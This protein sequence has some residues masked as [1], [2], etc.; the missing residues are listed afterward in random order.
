MKKV[1][2]IGGG[3]L[4]LSL[5]YELSQSGFAVTVLEK[6]KEWGGLASGLKIG[7]TYIEKYYHH[8]FRSDSAV[9]EL[10]KELG[11]GYKL[12]FLASSMGIYLDGKVH[13]FSGSLDL[14]KFKPLSFFYR[15]RAGIVSFYLQKSRYST[16][17][18]QLKALDWCY[19][20][21][22]KQPVDQIWKPLLQGKF[23]K[24]YKDI[25]MSWLWARIH[26][27]ASSRPNPIG[28]EYL[29]YLDGGFQVLIDT[30]VSKLQEFGVTMM[31]NADLQGYKKVGKKHLLRINDKE[32]EFDIVVSTVPGPVFMK[33]F[34]VSDKL[35]KQIT[36]I[37]YLGAICMVLELKQSLTPYYWLNI[38]DPKAPILALVEHTN[39]VAK[40]RYGDKIIV[41][42]AKYLDPE[43][44][45][46]KMTEDQLFELYCQYLPKVN[47]N[48][49]PDWVTAKHFFKSAYAQHVVTIGYKVPDYETDVEGLYYANFTQI[50]P[51][52]RGTNYAV[53]QAQTLSKLIIAKYGN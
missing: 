17:Y 33:I 34:P 12:E 36:S 28:K 48:F 46:F 43:S 19:R 3:M 41:Y 29:G 8:W 9:Q 51:H 20:Y 5:A 52:D 4:G 13:S 40:E 7:D 45:M 25:S 44:E 42:I 6:N 49:K 37:N 14:L 31:N 53:E 23:G 47:K 30:L 1:A 2:I 35:K 26:D 10:I 39:F 22:G 27:R 50:Y 15:L 11:L 38:N 18:E 32:K 24:Y 16:K 21:Y